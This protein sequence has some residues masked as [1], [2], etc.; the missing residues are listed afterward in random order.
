[1][2]V[3]PGLARHQGRRSVR[4]RRPR[5]DGHRH[6]PARSSRRARWTPLRAPTSCRC[7]S[8]GALRDRAERARG[9]GAAGDRRNRPP[10]AGALPDA[11]RHDHARGATRRLRRHGVDYRV[12]RR[13]DVGA[14]R[15]AHR[16]L[17]A[18][19]H[20][21]R[22][23]RLG[24]RRLTGFSLGVSCATSGRNCSSAFGTSSSETVLPR[25]MTRLEAAGVDRSIVGLVV[26]A[27]YSFNLDG[28]AVYLSMA[29]VFIAQATNTPL[30]I[31][32]RS[33]CW[34][35]ASRRKVRRGGR[36]GPR[37]CSPARWRR[38]RIPVAAGVGWCSASIGSWARGCAITNTIGNGVAALVIAK[39]SGPSSI[40]SVTEGL[41]SAAL[42]FAPANGCCQSGSESPKFK[43][44][45]R[46]ATPDLAKR[47]SRNRRSGSWRRVQARARR[48]A[49][50]VHPPATPAEVGAR[51]VREV[52]V[53]PI[54]AREDRVDQRQARRRAVAH[55]DRHGA[56][57]LD[58]RRRI[59]RA[60]ARRRARRSAPSR[61][62]AR[63]RLGVHRG[64]RGLQRVR[65]EPARAEARARPAR[66]PSAIC[67][68]FHSV[69]S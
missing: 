18:H 60:A 6:A 32:E 24:R 9:R 34:R 53:R 48:S 28:T 44:Q 22:G 35:S 42:G 16:Q 17:L 52:V 49:G 39:W 25:L 2:N 20:P 66:S 14:A 58:D 69:R 13:P 61:S 33:G 23:H 57:Q 63:R 56:I 46:R 50:L 64:D 62:R 19:V 36:C 59:G 15:R 7:C 12:V 65:A 21:L 8:S 47:R 11:R 51:R 43:A 55:R 5:A 4:H 1:M 68:R 29:T 10:G 27:G 54:A 67:S 30:G 41:S 45:S 37:R 38:P 40:R 3:D 31:R 26:P